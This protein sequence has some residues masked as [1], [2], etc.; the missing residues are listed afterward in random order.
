MPPNS[1]SNTRL[2]HISQDAL[3]EIIER[4]GLYTTGQTGGARAVLQYC[5][6]S[7]LDF[8]ESDLSNADF[9]ASTFSESNLSG[10]KLANSTFF[11]ADLRNCNLEDANMTR[12]DLRG[13]YLGG[14]NLAGAN[15]HGADISE[16]RIMERDERGILRD[17]KRRIG[18]GYATSFAGAKLNGTDLSN[19]NA[20]GADFSNADLS[21]ASFKGSTLQKA[22][23]SNTN[24][25]SADLDGA[26]LTNATFE[27]AIMIGTNIDNTEQKGIRFNNIVNAN[28]AGARLEDL[29]KSLIELLEEHTLWIKTRG[30]E[31]RQLDLSRFNLS[32]V[33]NLNQYPLTAIRAE[34]ANFLSQN[35][36]GAEMQSAIF[37]SSDFRDCNL[38]NADLRASS[39][40]FA[41]FN[42]A[43]MDGIKLCA[44]TFRSGT[45]HEQ[46]KICDLTG[47]S[48][49]FV[50]LKGAD[51][52][53]VIL[54]DADLTSA[55][56]SDANLEGADLRGAILKNT[57]MFDTNLEKTLRD[58]E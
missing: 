21:D 35:L 38:V 15:L 22:L 33:V 53:G 19:L 27:S 58:F 29:D 2:K 24:L 13:A 7:H 56:L 54:R 9:T 34:H 37:N 42:R 18:E 20:S 12:A 16:G 39:F 47:A 4:H 52:R 6:L 50:S 23:F 10:C 32:D 51:L 14:A 30:K 26:D 46:K 41:K 40:R 5:D 25:T 36:E 45:A 3:D 48:L 44:L 11:G 28:N 31:G 8:H 1:G 57:L 49:G 55:D 43:I 17:Q